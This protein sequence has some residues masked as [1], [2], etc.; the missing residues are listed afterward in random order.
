MMHEEGDRRVSDKLVEGRKMSNSL[1]AGYEAQG[2]VDRDRIYAERADVTERERLAQVIREN[3]DIDFGTDFDGETWLYEERLADKILAAG[4]WGI[5]TEGPEF[6]A[7]FERAKQAYMGHNRLRA[8]ILA[9]LGK[10]S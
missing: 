3:A 8:A 7:R 6:E 2:A 9:F 1:R 10:P 5:P 4:P